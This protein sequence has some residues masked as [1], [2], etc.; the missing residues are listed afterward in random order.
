MRLSTRARYALRMMLYLAKNG[1]DHQPVSLAT[2]SQQTGISRGY[3]EQLAIALRS[4][5]LVR[6][7]AGRYGGYRLA[8]SPH[9][10]T[11]G[12]VIEATIGPM[13]LVE[14]VEEPEVCNRS[15][16]CECRAVY[17]L[18]NQ[19]IGE[20]LD[21]F[22]LADMARS[23]WTVRVAEVAGIDSED[24]LPTSLP[25]APERNRPSEVGGC[26]VRSRKRG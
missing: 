10:I 4:A 18:I 9:E 5:S 6:G 1:G 21:E 12:T 8:R 13:R 14:C 22:T 19:R 2:I 15:D 26:P 3:L 17:R 11:I 24:D 23:D 7:V 25:I 16:N 20:V